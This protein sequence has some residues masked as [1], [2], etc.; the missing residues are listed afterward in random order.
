MCDMMQKFLAFFVGS[1]LVACEGAQQIMA[2]IIKSHDIRK[3]DFERG[4]NC[5]L[6]DRQ[7]K[8]YIDFESG[9]W[10]T[11]IGHSHPRINQVMKD[12]IDKVMHLGTRYPSYIAEEAALD[13]LD[14]VGIKDG[15]CTFLSSG[16]EAVEYAVQ[17]ARRITGKPKM[18]TFTT[19]YLAAYGSAGRK[20]AEEWLLLDWQSREHESPE[21]L[22]KD[23]QFEAL[24]GFV[25]EPGGSGISYVR[26]P[27]GDLV[28]E[29]VQRVKQAGGLLVVNEITTGM[30][31]TGKWFGF[32]H[33]DLQPD[34][35][36]LGK[37]V[38]NG[39]PVSVVAMTRDC[40]EK[41]EASDLHY[42]QSH[43]NDPLGCAVVREVI[44][45]IRENDLIARGVSIGEYFLEG[46]Q[47]LS[48]KHPMVKE[49]RGRGMLLALEF[50]PHESISAASIFDALLE[51]G[52]LVGV[53][54]EGDMLRFSPALTIEK[55]DIQLLLDALDGV[56]GSVE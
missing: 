33:Y 28:H 16:S 30:G 6:Y 49:A 14:I 8:R 27:P 1:F 18:L 5:Y 23:V 22:L 7:G 35:V 44:A 13:V 29:I 10:S 3:T 47:Q 36:A 32:Q 56:L 41:L 21:A 40:A 4:E 39:Y 43:Q 20:L 34:I 9:I 53:Y 15:K 19:S 51:G 11:S 50:H 26:F 12:Q 54:T 55:A 37:G 25:F 24:G 2:H 46:L 45:V 48:K 42:A 38:G 17:A 52:F 31:R